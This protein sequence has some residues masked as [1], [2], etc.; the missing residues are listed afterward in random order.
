M[1]REFK[2]EDKDAGSSKSESPAK[3]FT[4]DMLL[5]VKKSQ[6]AEMTFELNPELC[7]KK[8]TKFKFMTV[9]IK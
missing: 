8:P 6:L 4:L 1:V 7:R 3:K 5:K 9:K 2:E